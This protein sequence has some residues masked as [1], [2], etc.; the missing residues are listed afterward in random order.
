MVGICCPVKGLWRLGAI[1]WGSNAEF[2]ESRVRFVRGRVLRRRVGV[3]VVARGRWLLTDASVTL[4]L[5]L[6]LSLT[7]TLWPAPLSPSPSPSPSVTKVIT[8]NRY[9]A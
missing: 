2:L 3:V 4:T 9:Y 8:S 1:W 7:P 5:T 6:A